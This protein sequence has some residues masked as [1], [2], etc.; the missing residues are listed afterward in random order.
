MN[1]TS[2]PATALQRISLC[3][4]G[5]HKITA[6]LSISICTLLAGHSLSH[7]MQIHSW[8]W[9]YLLLLMRMWLVWS[10]IDWMIFCIL[11]MGDL[12]CLSGRV[13]LLVRL[14]IV[15]GLFEGLEHS[16]ICWF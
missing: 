6:L 4:L 12:S 15:V 16:E 14:N 2:V 9:L 1:Y 13:D 5:A 11:S 10:L 7:V 3:I 8:S